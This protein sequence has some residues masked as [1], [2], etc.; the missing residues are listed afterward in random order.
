VEV[1]AAVTAFHILIPVQASRTYSIRQEAERLARYL[2]VEV[3]AWEM[4]RSEAPSHIPAPF[5]VCAGVMCTSRMT[6]RRGAPHHPMEVEV[7]EAE[8]IPL[9][10]ASPGVRRGTEVVTLME[11]PD[12]ATSRINAPPLPVRAAALP[13]SRSGFRIS[14]QAPVQPPHAIAV[15]ALSTEAATRMSAREARPRRISQ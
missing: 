7:G 12:P 15:R 4:R 5:Q 2:S 6:R 8:A 11:A 10:P 13:V 1:A 9:V 14:R 3:G